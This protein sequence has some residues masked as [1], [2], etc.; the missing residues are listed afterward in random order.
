MSAAET[1]VTL[2]RAGTWEAMLEIQ[3]QAYPSSW[4]DEE[5]RELAERHL[6]AGRDELIELC[7]AACDG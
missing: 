3:M 2:A 5:R 6:T 7:E 1:F 4:T